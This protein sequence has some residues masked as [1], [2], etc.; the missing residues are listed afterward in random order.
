MKNIAI[1]ASGSGTNFEAIANAIESKSINCNLVLMVCDKAGAYVIERAKNHKVEALVFNPKEYASKKDYELMIIKRLKELNV[2]LIVLAGYMRIIG[3]TMLDEYE[4]RIIN[5]HPALLPSFKGAHGIED[6]FNYGVKVFGVT[7]HYVSKELDGGKIIDQEAFH[8]KEGETLGQV[9]GRI[10]EIEHVLY[11][12]VV[13]M[14]V[15][16]E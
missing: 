7:V 5:I 1:F 8:Y 12:R 9:E 11:P 6:A 3:D 10:H 15:E 4:N 16:G 14:L 13:K 2:D